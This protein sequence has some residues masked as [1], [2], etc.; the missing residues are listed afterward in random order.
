MIESCYVQVGVLPFFLPQRSWRSCKQLTLTRRLVFR[1]SRMHLRSRPFTA[2]NAADDP[3]CVII[4]DH[5]L[6]SCA[7]MFVDNVCLSF[8]FFSFCVYQ[9]NKDR[10]YNFSMSTILAFDFSPGPSSDNCLKCWSRG[11]CSCWQAIGAR[12]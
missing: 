9:F 6:Q 4:I 1:L 8:I 2:L 12:Q 3:F 7:F 5:V 11:C 10:T